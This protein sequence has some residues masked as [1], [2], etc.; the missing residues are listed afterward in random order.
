MCVCDGRSRHRKVDVTELL[1]SDVTVLRTIKFSV[2]T[3]AVN[4]MGGED[5]G[6]RMMWWYSILTS[7]YY[8]Y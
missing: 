1:C 8:A 2:E 6:G 4:A 5:E 7:E 3:I